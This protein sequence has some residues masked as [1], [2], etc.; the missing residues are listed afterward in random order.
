[1]LNNHVNTIRGITAKRISEQNLLPAQQ[2][3]SHPASN[4]CKDQL[5]LREATCEECSRRRKN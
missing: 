3:G 4:G 1:M 5:I 2:I